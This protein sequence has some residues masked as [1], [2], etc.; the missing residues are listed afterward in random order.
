MSNSTLDPEWD[1]SFIAS[2]L[3]RVANGGSAG[4]GRIEEVA[5]LTGDVKAA[6]DRAVKMP[7]ANKTV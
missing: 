4:R 1:P 6:H 2:A 7:K 3:E 5:P